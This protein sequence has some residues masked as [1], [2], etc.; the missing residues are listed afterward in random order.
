MLKKVVSFLSTCVF[1]AKVEY[2]LTEDKLHDGE[3]HFSNY[4]YAYAKRM[5]DVQARAYNDQY[6]VSRSERGLMSFGGKYISVIPTNI[7]GPNDNFEL[8]NS[9]VVPALIHKCYLAKQQ[10]LDF[11]VW[12]SGLPLR[13]FIYADDVGDLTQLILESYEDA[14][15]LILSSSEEVSIRDLVQVIVEAMDYEGKVFFDGS[16]PD[17]QY[18]KS[19]SNSKLQSFVP[20]YR[21]TSLKKGIE[22]TVKWFIKNYETCRK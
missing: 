21:F 18:R 19:T 8:G 22:Q 11:M 16:K 1:P 12:G 6:G 5:L 10:K 9:H 2:P 13:E 7:Y 15:P 20:G 17:G 3:P 4:G 14:D